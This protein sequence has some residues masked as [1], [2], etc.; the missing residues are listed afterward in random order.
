M[1]QYVFL[2]YDDENDF[3]S[4]SPEELGP[5]MEAWGAYTQ[6][7]MDAGAFVAGEPLDHSKTARR[8]RVRDGERSVED[9]PF[10]DAKEQLGGFYRI[11]AK[12]LDEA[13]KWAAKCPCASSGRIEIRPVWNIG[14]A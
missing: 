5:V 12:D 1:M 13:M 10:A 14:G 11:E 2:L 7:M 8:V 6:E 4:L 9:G 3:H